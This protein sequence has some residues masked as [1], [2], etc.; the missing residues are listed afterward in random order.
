[1]PEVTLLPCPACADPKGRMQG[2][3]SVFLAQLDRAW[4]CG[5]WWYRVICAD[6]GKRGKAGCSGEEASNY[7][8]G[9]IYEDELPSAI[10][11]TTEPP[12][13]AGFY[14][15]LMSSGTVGTVY[16]SEADINDKDWHGCVGQ[17]TRISG[18]IPTPKEPTL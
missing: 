8:N 11:W 10:A 4:D 15:L 2:G 1:M 7:W 17:W 13:V 14:F 3:K 12:K 18:P 9:G 6:C 5:G 16:L